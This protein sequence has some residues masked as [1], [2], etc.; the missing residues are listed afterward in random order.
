[1]QKLHSMRV[2]ITQAKVVPNVGCNKPLD[3]PRSPGSDLN[4][5]IRTDSMCSVKCAKATWNY[6]TGTHSA[7]L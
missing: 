5:M 1:M 3:T 6:K 7:L 2:Q 4:P